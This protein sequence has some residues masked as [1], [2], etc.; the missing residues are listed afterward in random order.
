MLRNVYYILQWQYCVC[1]TILLVSGALSSFTLFPRSPL[2]VSQVVPN[3]ARSCFSLLP[4]AFLVSLNYRKSKWERLANRVY[5][6]LQ[7][8]CTEVFKSF[9]LCRIG[10]L[11]VWPCV[12]VWQTTLQWL[13]I[14]DFEK[15]FSNIK[16][17][18]A[19]MTTL[20]KNIPYSHNSS[21]SCN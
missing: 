15:G 6:S 9:F 3:G 21:L 8:E 11:Y 10:V 17:K 19:V 7:I 5:W 12:F 18:L 4:R 14:N 13:V 1:K 16:T 20:Q 2:E